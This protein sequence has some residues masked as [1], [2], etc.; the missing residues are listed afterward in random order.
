MKEKIDIQLELLSELNE[1][2]AQNNL[3]YILLGTNALNGY[4]NKTLKNGSRY[5]SVA[6]TNGDIER[7][8]DVIE[9][10]YS[11]NRY[12]EGIFNNPFFVPF[13]VTYGNK[14]TTDFYVAN[15]NKNVYHGIHIR[16]Y[17]ICKYAKKKGKELK[18]W[19]E[20]LTKNKE[21]RESFTNPVENN[22]WKKN[23][24]AHLYP[25]F[26]RNERYYKQYK[27]Y[28]AIDKWE[29]IQEYLIVRIDKKTF[30]SKIFKSTEKYE[31]D[32]THIFLPKDTDAYFTRI[33]GKNF[34]KKKIEKQLNT[35]REIV[36]TELGYEEVIKQNSKLLKEA[37]SHKQELEI[38]IFNQNDEKE[39]SAK[40]WKLVQMTHKQVGFRHHFSYY[41]TNYL[42]SKDLSNKNEFNEVYNELRPVINTLNRYAEYDLTFSVNPKIDGLIKEVLIKKNNIELLDKI[43]MLSQK[44]FLI[45]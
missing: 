43:E 38:E 4:Q 12:V 42:L 28:N 17:P 11:E 19:D 30:F 14:N 36:D 31:V 3:K 10:E 39:I 25:H 35:K 23:V 45:E 9:R 21:Y 22:F 40:L 32:D 20:N 2:C 7:F 16:L 29:Y 37:V 24:E 15:Y 8:C 33:F 18:S 26:G 27:I 44:E 34:R 6:M 5:V 1:I 13:Y 41:K